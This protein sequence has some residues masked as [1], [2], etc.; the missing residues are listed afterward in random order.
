MAV[1]AGDQVGKE[2]G[3][4]AVCRRDGAG[5]SGAVARRQ[6]TGSVASV[7]QNTT[8]SPA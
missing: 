6:S 5:C 3:R 7:T 2:G 1:T 8:E 4:R